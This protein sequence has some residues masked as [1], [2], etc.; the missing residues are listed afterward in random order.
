MGV[1]TVRLSEELHEAFRNL[2]YRCRKSMN[3]VAVELFTAATKPSPRG[4][5]M[6]RFKVKPTWKEAYVAQRCAEVIGSSRGCPPYQ[7][8]NGSWV[9]N[10][11]NDWWLSKEDNDEYRLEYRYEHPGIPMEALKTFLAWVFEDKAI[12]QPE[13]EQQEG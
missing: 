12:H 7:K 2:A 13:A 10:A 4:P 6:I 5:Y 9:L 3:E 1:I 8:E 11:S